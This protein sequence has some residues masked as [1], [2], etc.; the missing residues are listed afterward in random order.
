MIDKGVS[1]CTGYIL[2]SQGK[3]VWLSKSQLMLL[4]GHGAVD[5]VH[6]LTCSY[7]KSDSGEC[8]THIHVKMWCQPKQF[9][10]PL[11]TPFYCSVFY[12]LILLCDENIV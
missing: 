9:N 2:T 5:L 6:D 12:I 7:G 10:L 8:K 1:A 4:H 11:N 3:K